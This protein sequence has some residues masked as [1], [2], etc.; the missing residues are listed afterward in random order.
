MVRLLFLVETSAN[1]VYEKRRKFETGFEVG[2]AALLLSQF[3]EFF[4]LLRV[5]VAVLNAFHFDL[6]S[7][8]GEMTSQ[9]RKIH[10]KLVDTILPEIQ[11]I[12]TKSVRSEIFL[13]LIFMK[14]YV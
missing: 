11:S 2:I 7:E 1:D 4:F 13:R 12:L 14:S 3:P 6:S 5:L 10:D 8:Q 9:Q